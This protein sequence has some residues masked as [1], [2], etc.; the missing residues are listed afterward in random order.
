MLFAALSRGKYRAQFEEEAY[1]YFHGPWRR[2]PAIP[3]ESLEFATTAFRE[4][5]R[6]FLLMQNEFPTAERTFG[7]VSQSLRLILSSGAALDGPTEWVARNQAASL[8]HNEPAKLCDAM[9]KNFADH[10]G[11]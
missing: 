7:A 6:F 5:E 11:R 8:W 4:A 10:G 3:Y 1:V 2:S 9:F